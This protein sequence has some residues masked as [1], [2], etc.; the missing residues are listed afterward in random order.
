MQMGQREVVAGDGGDTVRIGRWEVEEKGT[1][2]FWGTV[3]GEALAEDWWAGEERDTVFAK[4]ISGICGDISVSL[5]D[6]EGDLGFL[7]VEPEMSGGGSSRPCAALR[8]SCR[9]KS[10]ACH[11]SR[12]L[13][14][15]MD[16][17]RRILRLESKRGY[18]IVE[19]VRGLRREFD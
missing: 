17:G 4:A 5:E 13:R 7:D 8:E 15:K 18:T 11:H 10:E 2:R 12:N 14:A 6:D 16:V 1:W 3:V 19:R 9:A